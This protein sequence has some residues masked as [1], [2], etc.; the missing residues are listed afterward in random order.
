MSNEDPFNE[1]LRNWVETSM[2]RSMHAFI[3]YSRESSLSL[4]QINSLFRLYHHGPS[5]VND[6]SDH[7]GIT[8]AAVSQLLAPLEDAGLIKRS[9]DPSDR[10]VKRII[11]TEKGT[12]HV[13]E[14]MRARHAWLADLAS[15]L[16]PLEKAQLL[17]A[18]LLLNK[19]S[20]TL[21]QRHQHTHNHTCANSAVD[22]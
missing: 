12:L 11:L 16:T 9:E 20:L 4:S 1:A 18:L 7:L 22:N 21:A 2:H 8:M 3:R 15:L 14:S 6:L 5:P 17:P 19:H 13:R 10:R